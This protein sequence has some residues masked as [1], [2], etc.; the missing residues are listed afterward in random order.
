[1][2]ASAKT[3]HKFDTSILEPDEIKNN[4]EGKG[5]YE[6]KTMV[7]V[8]EIMSKSSNCCFM[9]SRT[10]HNINDIFEQFITMFNV[11]PFIKKCNKT[12]I[13]E[14]HFK[15]KADNL[16]LFCCDPNDINIIDYKQVQKLC[17]QNNI[18]WTNQTYMQ[19]ITQLKINFFDMQNI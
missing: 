11:F 9:Y 12:N 2:V 10:T 17:V 3:E 14:F 8:K 7:E 13:M 15:L 1:M 4:F 5:I 16:H 6:N 19:F 18:E